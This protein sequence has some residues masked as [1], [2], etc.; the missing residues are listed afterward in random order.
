MKLRKTNRD[1]ETE[2][3]ESP[4]RH[5]FLKSRK[6]SLGAYIGLGAVI[7]IVGIIL[8]SVWWFGSAKINPLSIAGS[9]GGGNNDGSGGLITL[10]TAYTYGGI[11]PFNSSDIGGTDY[12]KQGSNAPVTSLAAPEIGAEVQL[13][14]STAGHICEVAKTTA[15]QGPH[16]LN[17]NCYQNSTETITFYSQPANTALTA[18]T[19]TGTGASNLS[20]ATS[21]VQFRFY[22]NSEQYK[23]NFALGGCFAAEY[24][25]TVTQ[26][27][28]SGALSTAKPCPS[29]FHWTY[30]PASTSNAYRLYEIPAGF[31][32]DGTGIQKQVDGIIKSSSDITSGNLIIT[33]QPA[34]PYKSKKGNFVVDI[35][36]FENDD[37]TK[38]FP[39]S[40]VG[41]IA[42]S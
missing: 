7:L 29:N 36:K 24:P 8:M 26:F 5:G 27:T 3:R 42:L 19:T 33:M 10:T 40:V 28:L 18:T 6:G 37:T 41:A 23:P 4:V 20:V 13:W 12:I 31:D 16:A 32:I 38:A 14:R 30:S 21:Q 34:S 39:S 17:T 22:L 15:I 2:I 25:N 1:E 11:N 9:S 35:E